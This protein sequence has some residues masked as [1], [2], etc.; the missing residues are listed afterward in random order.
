MFISHLLRF[1]VSMETHSMWVVAVG[2]QERPYP[3]LKFCNIDSPNTLDSHS[4]ISAAFQNVCSH[5][6]FK[7]L[8]DFLHKK[9]GNCILY[10]HPG[11]GY[12]VSSCGQSVVLLLFIYSFIHLLFWYS[13]TKY[14]IICGFGFFFNGSMI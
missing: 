8:K 6:L 13:F 7:A 10:L 3:L 11:C 1:M 14:R 2:T 4:L 9:E 5:L 12:S